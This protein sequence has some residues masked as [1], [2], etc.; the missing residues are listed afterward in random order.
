M[1]P[2]KTMD[3]TIFSENQ[4][5]LG[6][7]L[8]LFLLSSGITLGLFV[9]FHSLSPF[10]YFTNDDL[11]FKTIA[12]GEVMGQPCSRLWY[13]GYPVGLVIS[14]FYKMIPTLPW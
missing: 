7:K 5:E 13:I 14:F 4:I 2:H 8:I 3:N 11:F 12:S 9:Y 10:I 1:K 6:K